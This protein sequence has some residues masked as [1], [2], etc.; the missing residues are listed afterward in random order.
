VTY[1]ALATVRPVT[2]GRVAAAEQEV[3]APVTK[4]A[5]AALGYGDVVGD[6]EGWEPVGK[7][8]T[9]YPDDRA[10]VPPYGYGAAIG[11]WV[12]TVRI[13]DLAL[14]S[15]PGELFGSIR[16]ALAKGIHA[17]DGVFVVGAA[18]DFLGYEYP[19]YVTPFTN[20]GGDELIFGPS[21]TL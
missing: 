10:I 1:R 8:F 6:G 20:L 18:Q 14:V 2:V 15:E 17:P 3:V 4:P 19:V 12:T 16:D 9:V 7:I 13:G 5:D 21:A 11:T